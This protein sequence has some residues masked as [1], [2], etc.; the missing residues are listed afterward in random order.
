ME[1]MRWVGG[2]D[3]IFE[4]EN[5]V[6]EVCCT[7]R[8]L[9]RIGKVRVFATKLCTRWDG[10][11]LPI[12]IFWR[13]SVHFACSMLRVGIATS[14]LDTRRLDLP[15]RPQTNMLCLRCSRGASVLSGLSK[16]VKTSSTTPA[17]RYLTPNH[18]PHHLPPN[19]LTL[20]P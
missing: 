17:K 15:S 18:P 13:W 6:F 2:L 7:W 4:G 5:L 1:G 10:E 19:V 20:N 3:V 9:V 16:G 14:C 12:I 11:L 8:E